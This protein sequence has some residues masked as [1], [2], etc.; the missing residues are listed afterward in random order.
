MGVA[1]TLLDLWFHR[2]LRHLKRTVPFIVVPLR[3]P[4]RRTAS[5]NPSAIGSSFTPLPG[6]KNHRFERPTGLRDGPCSFR[7]VPRVPER[8]LLSYPKSCSVLRAR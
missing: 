3:V 4:C 2:S 6:G 7:K 8:V 5:T 1:P